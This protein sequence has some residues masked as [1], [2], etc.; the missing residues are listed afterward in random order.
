MI[1]IQNLTKTYP[2]K[3]IYEDANLNIYDN[4]RIGLIGRNGVGKSTLLEILVDS[5]AY[6]GNV[7]IPKDTKI[8]YY[9]QDLA[10]GSNITVEEVLYKPFE[11]LFEMERKMLELS[12]DF[13][14]NQ[15]EYNEL[16]E[17]FER[18]GGYFIS[19]NIN[20]MISKFKL[21]DI[22]SQNIDTLSGGQKGRVALAKVLLENPDVLLLDEP[23]NHLDIEAIEWLEGFLKKYSNKLIVISHDRYFL[24]NICN[25]IVNVRHKQLYKYKGNYSA[26]LKQSTHNL[27]TLKSEYDKQQVQIKKL[28]EQIKQYRIWGESRSSEKMFAKAK[29]L[30]KRLAKIDV[31]DN[32]YLNDKDMRL[33]ITTYK[34]SGYNVAWTDYLAI[35]YDDILIDNIKFDIYLGERVAFIGPN[36]TGKSTLLKIIANKLSPLKGEVE[37]GAN[38]KIAY[39]D[40]IFENLD[41]SKTVFEEIHS[42]NILLT[43]FQIRSH[44]AKFLFTNDELDKSVGSLSGGEC[45]RVALAKLTLEESNV[46]VL[47]EP[48]NHLDLESK[49]ILEESLIDYEGTIIFSSHDRYFINKLATKIFDFSD[50]TFTLLDMTYNEYINLKQEVVEEKE[51]TE[52]KQ[53]FTENKKSRSI[54]QKI[55]KIEEEIELLSSRVSVLEKSKFDYDV[56]TSSKNHEE[57]ESQIANLNNEIEKLI[58]QTMELEEEL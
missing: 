32:P 25:V 26:F 14:K 29:E 52:E 5:I 27:D 37:L 55:T 47:D 38:V 3:I 49:Q 48:T 23:L 54:K 57:V 21:E 24:D 16:Y 20:Q 30:E 17:S 39:F 10:I 22:L 45:V 56:Y 46:L 33:T 42:G 11:E 12:Y 51:I 2:S 6:E 28:N 4:E 1:Q 7:N 50:N 44:L 19:T 35:G 53:S 31:I 43:N 36:G 9:T 15:D 18:K 40:Q 13:I 8:G 34:K 41:K 58:T